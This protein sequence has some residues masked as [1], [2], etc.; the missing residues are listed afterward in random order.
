MIFPLNFFT[1]ILHEPAQPDFIALFLHQSWPPSSASV[2]W[3]PEMSDTESPTRSAR[4][5]LRVRDAAG[6]LGMGV[7]TL[8]KLRLT[9]GGPPF[10]KHTSIVLYDRA[11]LDRWAE[12]RKVR[13]TSQRPLAD[14]P[15]R[16]APR[17]R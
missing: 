7:S 15:R 4:R 1:R 5:W 6:H 3:S 2:R 8:N 9:G 12:E 11:D 10:V 16:V 17:T 13:S 14:P